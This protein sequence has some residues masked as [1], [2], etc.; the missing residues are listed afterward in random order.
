MITHCLG[1]IANQLRDNTFRN[2]WSFHHADR[3]MPER[4]KGVIVGVAEAGGLKF[5]SLF[6]G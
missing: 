2:A 3:R 1:L 5:A 4:V 6:S